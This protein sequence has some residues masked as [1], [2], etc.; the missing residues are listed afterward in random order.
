MELQTQQKSPQSIHTDDATT[1][2]ING[3]ANLMPSGGA[4]DAGP[5]SQQQPSTLTSINS[6]DF[7]T[8]DGVRYNVPSKPVIIIMNEVM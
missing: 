6:A 4:G 8:L 1:T 5:P 3:G 2:T 7:F